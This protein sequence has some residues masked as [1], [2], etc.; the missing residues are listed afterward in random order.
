MTD[1]QIILDLL[2]FYKRKGTNLSY[3]LDDP[4]FEKLPLKFKV[5]FMRKHAKIILDGSHSSVS[6]GDI[7]QVVSSA[8]LGAT[9]G[10]IAGLTAVKALSS[11]TLTPGFAGKYGIGVGGAGG[12]LLG[13]IR[14]YEPIARRK[15]MRASLE[16]AVNNPSISNSVGLLSSNKIH[17]VNSVTRNSI[18]NNVASTMNQN[19][20]DMIP[21]GIKSLDAAHREAEE[22]TA[23]GIAEYEKQYG[24]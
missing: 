11:P 21:L 9:T 18:L 14:G 3:L 10:A 20:R 13:V 6:L 15:A 7:G 8:A 23:R 19:T 22:A 4:L 17:S 24:K 5:E 2:A 1:E 16:E 12:L